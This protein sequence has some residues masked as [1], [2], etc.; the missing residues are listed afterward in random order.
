MYVHLAQTDDL[1]S[2]LEGRYHLLSSSVLSHEGVTVRAGLQAK[3]SIGVMRAIRFR[4]M[5]HP[6][7][8]RDAVLNQPGAVDPV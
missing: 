7:H 1:V 8:K 2:V 4:G 6:M 5:R 3:K